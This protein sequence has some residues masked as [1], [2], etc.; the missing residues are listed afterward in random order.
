MPAVAK[1]SLA[2]HRDTGDSRQALLGALRRSS[3]PL[4][5][6]EAGRIVGLRRNSARAHL[7]VLV[8]IGLARRLVETRSTRGRPRVLYERATS[9]PETRE[10]SRAE[11]DLAYLDLGYLELAQ[12]LAGQ[13]T[14]MEGASSEAVRAGRR[15]AAAVDSSPLVLGNGT[16]LEAMDAVVNL[17][18]RLGFE[19]ELLADE[20][21]ILLHHCPFVEVA[22]QAR[23]IVCG[24]HLGMLQAT[25]ERHDAAIE[26][27]GFLPFVEDDPILCVVKVA[28]KLLQ[29]KVSTRRERVTGANREK[30]SSLP[31]T[32]PRSRRHPDA[33]HTKE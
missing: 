9:L 12:L 23:P 5:A 33:E 1:K 28:E 10:G 7:E 17:F 26:V 21:K 6:T 2:G 22:K 16:P 8:S 25:L 3:H 18:T 31:A 30:A 19:P 14:E 20:G 24:M 29:S 15:W 11:G 27:T 13:L 4:D 32:A